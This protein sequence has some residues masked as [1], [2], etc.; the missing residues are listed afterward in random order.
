M[1]PN[2]TGRSAL[3]QIP[4][5]NGPSIT[6]I[7]A[8]SLTPGTH[9]NA[10]GVGNA[11][12]ITRELFNDIDLEVT[13]TNC[14]AAGAVRFCKIPAILD[15]EEDAVRAAIYTCPRVDYSQ[16]K[17]VRIKD[18]LHLTNIQVSES[19]LPYCASHSCFTI[20]Q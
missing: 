18:T 19:L 16:A 13:Y 11:D 2:I 9:H 17:V 12:F 20:Q 10:A 3:G 1:D 14:I 6:N 5:F 8:L 7:V 15:N 4:N